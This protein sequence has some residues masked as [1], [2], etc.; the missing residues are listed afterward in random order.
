MTSGLD[1][2]RGKGR[3][4]PKICYFWE[5]GK[6]D[7]FVWDLCAILIMIVGE[8]LVGKGGPL[9]NLGVLRKEPELECLGC[10]VCEL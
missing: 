8:G 5:K 1:I 7:F 2:R 3:K 10:W 6:N 9:V 4:I